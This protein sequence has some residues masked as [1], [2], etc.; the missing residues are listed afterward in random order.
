MNKTPKV[1]VIEDKR[2]EMESIVRYLKRYTPFNILG[3]DKVKNAFID[4]L[5]D[6]KTDVIVTDFR[7]PE[8]S[9]RNVIDLVV[10]Y[11]PNIRIVIHSAWLGD[12][13]E[14]FV[15]DNIPKYR[16]VTGVVDKAQDIRA[17]LTALNTAVQLSLDSKTLE[18]SDIMGLIYV[19]T[20]QDER[21]P[22]LKYHSRNVTCL[23]IKMGKLLGLDQN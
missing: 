22:H 21:Y 18:V 19:A 5:K 3:F 9:G 1:V 11:N 16:Q 15:K 2:N 6:D 8:W 4:I 7:M 12:Y 14:N 20:A 10:N 13:F 23:S 17:L